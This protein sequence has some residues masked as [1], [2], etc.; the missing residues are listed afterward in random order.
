ME[1]TC[2]LVGIIE[3]LEVIKHAGPLHAQLT[4]P[5]KAAKAEEA[6]PAEAAKKDAKKAEEPKKLGEKK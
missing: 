5:K 2:V 1:W 3:T 6:K 4:E